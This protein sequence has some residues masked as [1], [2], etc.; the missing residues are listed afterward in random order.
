MEEKIISIQEV[1]KN[2]KEITEKAKNGQS[3]LVMKH[4]EPVF[5]IDPYHEEDKR[6]NG[7]KQESEFIEKKEEPQSRSNP[8]KDLDERS[9]NNKYCLEDIEDLEFEEEED[10]SQTIDEKLYGKKNNS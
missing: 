6:Q 10:L 9:G 1:Y 7:N 3:F 5:H 4:S 2:L 8:R